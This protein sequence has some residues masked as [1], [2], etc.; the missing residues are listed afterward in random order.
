MVQ[1]WRN[2]ETDRSSFWVGPSHRTCFSTSRSVLGQEVAKDESASMFQLWLSRHVQ[3]Q[4]VTAGVS[5]DGAGAVS[6]ASKASERIASF[7]DPLV[8]PRRNH[9]LPAASLW[10]R[11]LMS[12][13]TTAAGRAPTLVRVSVPFCGGKRGP[14]FACVPSLSLRRAFPSNLMAK[15]THRPRVATLGGAIHGLGD[16]CQSIRDFAIVVC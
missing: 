14:P 5:T 16:R 9:I 1:G 13:T 4:I 11:V 3:C 15:G 7:G 8:S 2:P 10:R 12:R 6:V